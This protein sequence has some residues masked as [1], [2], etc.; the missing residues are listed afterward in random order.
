MVTSR[1]SKVLTTPIAFS[2]AS[3]GGPDK[4][5]EPQEQDKGQGEGEQASGNKSVSGWLKNKI[6]R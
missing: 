2:L 1:A 3:Q 5:E 6:G 4:V